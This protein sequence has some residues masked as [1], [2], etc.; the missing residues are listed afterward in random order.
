VAIYEIDVENAELVRIFDGGSRDPSAVDTWVAP[1][2]KGRLLIHIAGTGLA[3]LDTRAAR[4]AAQL[5]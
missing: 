1:A 3:V 5:E 4:Q 2:G